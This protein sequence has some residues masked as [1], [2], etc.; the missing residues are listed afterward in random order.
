MLRLSLEKRK[1]QV[2]RCMCVRVC[3]IL[4][5]TPEHGWKQGILSVAVQEMPCASVVS[6]SIQNAPDCKLK[7]CGTTDDAPGLRVINISWEWMQVVF[8]PFLTLSYCVEL[9]ICRY[10]FLRFTLKVNACSKLVG[11]CVCVRSWRVIK[12]EI[13]AIW[14]AHNGLCVVLWVSLGLDVR[15]PW[16]N[17]E[18]P[19]AEALWSSAE[20]INS[21]VLL[22][23]WPSC[24]HAAH[25]SKHFNGQNKE[26]QR[27][28]SATSL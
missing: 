6:H 9:Q 13:W 17:P 20:G 4:C 24:S 12:R 18:P 27:E 22:P 3:N 5:V 14:L 2:P 8:D 11:S 28:S 10:L 19:S 15:P 7:L 23:F 26:K 1:V 25:K 21:I 16:W